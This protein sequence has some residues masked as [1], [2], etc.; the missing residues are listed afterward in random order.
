[1]Q[2]QS[3]PDNLEASY[4]NT[5]IEMLGGHIKAFDRIA[6]K[7]TIEL[8][9]KWHE[10][11]GIIYF[12]I[13]FDGTTGNEWRTR[14]KNSDFKITKR[15]RFLLDSSDFEPISGVTHRLAI[16]RAPLFKNKKYLMSEAYAEADRLGFVELN[17]GA[18]CRFRE[19]F[20]N[21]DIRNMG[22]RY[23]IFGHKPMADI[24]GDF[25]LMSVDIVNFD[26]PDLDTLDIWPSR[27]W[28]SDCGFVFCSQALS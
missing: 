17:L 8:M 9:P 21:M 1:M 22:F 26:R 14:L 23:L 13:A 11:R 16:L 7:N 27:S 19:K 28:D 12:N 5:L 4:L 10:E 25:D 20:T 3:L 2:M 24:D 6:G 18:A 15:A